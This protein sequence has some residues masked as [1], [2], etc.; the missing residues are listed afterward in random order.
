MVKSTITLILLTT[1]IF[2][3]FF[4]PTPAEMISGTFALGIVILPLAAIFYV[5]FISLVTVAF[6]KMYEYMMDVSD[7]TN[8]HINSETISL[9]KK[10]PKYMYFIV[11]GI[12]FY[13][14]YPSDEIV[15][16]G[17]IDSSTQYSVDVEYRAERGGLFCSTG[18]LFGGFSRRA[19]EDR[20]FPRLKANKHYLSIPKEK[21]SFGLCDYQIN[22]IKM[23]IN[24]NEILLFE[25]KHNL[26]YIN[27]QIGKHS[28][29]N[30]EHINLIKVE[31]NHYTLD[32]GAVNNIGIKKQNTKKKSS[33]R[34]KQKNP[35]ATEEGII[36]AYGPTYDRSR[37]YEKE[38]DDRIRF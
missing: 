1:Y 20:Y 28:S 19:K 37:D 38:Y 33:Y 34:I 13:Y 36:E 3:V 27:K 30:S 12:L 35:F 8:E 24:S 18:T 31:K 16:K 2:I 9:L 26:V 17:R 11:I 7:D 10:N 29:I 21:F 32:I 4:F 25:K 15:L 5:V 14:F 23:N 6:W 22:T